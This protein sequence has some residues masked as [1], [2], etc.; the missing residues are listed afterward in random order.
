MRDPPH[1]CPHPKAAPTL[2]QL[3][4]ALRLPPASGLHGCAG[5]AGWVPGGPPCL[6]CCCPPWACLRPSACGKRPLCT[7]S[8]AS[9]VT[10]GVTMLSCLHL[11]SC[12][13]SQDGS[14][15]QCHPSGVVCPH[16]QKRDL[17]QVPLPQRRP[18][19]Q[20]LPGPTL[21]SLPGLRQLPKVRVTNRDI[22]ATSSSLTDL[23]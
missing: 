18:R 1:P 3:G 2:G 21:Q 9:V 15:G 5:T 6:W 13:H 14:E 19:L 8:R 4:R 22:P 12:L 16:S 10:S 20:A 23:E 7:R 11:L 17:E